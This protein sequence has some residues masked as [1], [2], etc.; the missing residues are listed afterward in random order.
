MCRGV[1][2]LLLGFD[3][4]IIPGVTWPWSSSSS[5]KGHFVL[6]IC[7]SRHRTSIAVGHSP[8]LCLFS[9]NLAP[10]LVQPLVSLVTFTIS[11]ELMPIYPLH[12]HVSPPFRRGVYSLHT[13]EFHYS[14]SIFRITFSQTSYLI[15]SCRDNKNLP[16]GPLKNSLSASLNDLLVSTKN[17]MMYPSRILSNHASTTHDDLLSISCNS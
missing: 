6:C 13:L 10:P 8:I 9:Q 16:H 4:V 1:G 7:S 5:Q 17:L 12:F 2:N 14:W 15:D 3:P 11:P